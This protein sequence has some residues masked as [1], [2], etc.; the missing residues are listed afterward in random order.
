MSTQVGTI[1]DVEDVIPGSTINSR[2]ARPAWSASSPSPARF[3]RF[4]GHKVKVTLRE[5]VENQN[6]TGWARTTF[7]TAGA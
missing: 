5:P 4:I 3:E 2:S 6:A 7:R 1:L